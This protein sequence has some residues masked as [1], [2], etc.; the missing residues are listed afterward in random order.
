[1]SDNDVG[2]LAILMVFGLPLAYGI[3]SR[4]FAHHERLEM[5]RRGIAPPPDPRWM[6]KMAKSKW[7]DPATYGATPYWVQP[8]Q[9]P[10][11]APPAYDPYGYTL[12]QA[13]RQLRSGIVVT[14]VGFAILVGLSLIHPGHPGAELLGGLIPLF[15]GI[16]QIILA[17][18][19]GARFG[20][21][22]L[23]PAQ[24]PPPPP[25]AGQPQTGASPQP[26]FGAPGPDISPGGPYGWRP[27]PTAELERPSPPP[28]ARRQ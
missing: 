17:L 9:Q 18:L 15:I 7:Y 25:Q 12:Y 11:V 23:G 8:P 21:F 5:I 4:V 19:S 28:D 13:N 22:T 14:L 27:G 3:I 1:M 2:A 6:R 20:A 24:A 26:P 10:Y 16:A